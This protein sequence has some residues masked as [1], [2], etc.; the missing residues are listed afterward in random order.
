MRLP[1]SLTS[2]SL[3]LIALAS[4]AIAQKDAPDAAKQHAEKIAE[5]VAANWAS[6]PVEEVTQ[7]SKGTARVDG[8]SIPYTQTAGTLTI[9]DEK[10]KPVAS[11]F[12]TAYTCLLYT[13]PSPRDS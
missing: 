7:S 8:K 10:G 9:R 12:Y 5:D 11:M 4:P 13:S 3:S 6:A 2:F 1:K